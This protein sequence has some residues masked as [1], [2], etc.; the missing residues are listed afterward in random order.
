MKIVYYK[1]VKIT[2][3]APNLVEV[4]INV[5]VR[6][7]GLYDFIVTDQILLFTLKF[8]SLLCYFLGI[9]QKLSIPFYSQM[10]GQTKRQHN[11]MKAYFRAFINFKQNI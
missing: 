10:D 4:I 11:I 3:D 6:H 1:L 7:H 2:I 8:W 5:I 9:K